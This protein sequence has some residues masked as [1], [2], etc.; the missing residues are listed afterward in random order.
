M[1]LWIVVV[2]MFLFIIQVG[3]VLIIEFKNP[4]KT[5]AWLLIIF[6]LP[7]LGFILYFFVAREY[8]KRR[9]V[10]RHGSR[11][12]YLL[13]EG[14]RHNVDVAMKAKEMRNP[15][16]A[17]QKRL[18]GLLQSI[19]ESPITLCNETEIYSD[20]VAT[21]DAIIEALE[22]AKDH[23]H[24]EYYIIHS[25]E[26]GTVIQNILLR[27]AKAGVDVRLMYDGL[28]SYKLKESFIRKLTDGGVKVG[29]FFPLRAAF[30]TKNLNYRNH[31]KIIVVD[32]LVG[33]LGGINIGDE[34]LGRNPR[35]GFWRDTHMRII[36]DAVYF[37][38]QTFI[39]DWEFVTGEKLMDARYYP[40]H[41]CVGEER[42]QIL[43]S[44]P[45]A[46]WDT[47]LEL[48]FSAIST[49]VNRIYLETPYFIPDFSILMALKTAALS[50]VEVRIILPGI[51]DHAL[52]K[53][54]S[55]AYIEDLMMAGVHFYQYQ[56][57]FIHAKILI[58]D[59]TVATVGTA[60]LDMRS[61]FDNFEMNAVMFDKETIRKLDEDF[62]EDLEKSEEMNLEDFRTRSRIQ[63]AK[64]V[65]ARMLSPLL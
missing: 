46:E 30:F 36:G 35:F 43:N 11:V 6:L 27:K 52:V 49:A 14:V 28:G 4:S 51:S 63:R 8:R 37:L 50:G 2:A 12:K 23:I 54:A 15:D 55:N 40:E 64:E 62:Q 42:V 7:V 58:V 10:K 53:S 3:T 38:Q 44:G 32:G 19:P 16:V 56:A 59:E 22:H 48:Y 31:R 24:L 17:K 47:I 39:S 25:D 20:G 41:H 34:Y 9:Y 60:N 61:F 5:T 26:I 57:G 13:P 45:D 33:F 18:F 29:C 1:L 21:F 65:F